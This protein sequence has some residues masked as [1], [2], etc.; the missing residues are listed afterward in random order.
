MKSLRN[1]FTCTSVCNN[2]TCAIFEANNCTA[3]AS[4]RQKGHLAMV[5]LAQWNDR[6]VLKLHIESCNSL[7]KTEKIAQLHQK[8]PLARALRQPLRKL[9]KALRNIYL[10]VESA[11]MEPKSFSPHSW[12]RARGEARVSVWDDG[13]HRRALSTLLTAAAAIQNQSAPILK[14]A[15]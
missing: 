5:T 1:F 6:N 3:R 11:L 9:E 13:L 4:R 12:E 2:C 7:G 10:W 14:A 15:A 8:A